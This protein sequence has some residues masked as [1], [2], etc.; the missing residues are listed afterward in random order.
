MWNILFVSP[1]IL[2]NKTAEHSHRQHCHVDGVQC[3]HSS[4]GRSWS[5]FWSWFWS[6]SCVLS[7]G[8]QNLRGAGASVASDWRENPQWTSVFGFVFTSHGSLKRLLQSDLKKLSRTVARMC[9]SGEDVEK[10]DLWAVGWSKRR[11]WK[12]KNSV[13]DWQNTP[14]PLTHHT[15]TCLSLA[16]SLVP[17]LDKT[18][19]TE[20]QNLV[21]NSVSLISSPPLQSVLAD[22]SPPA[23][24]I[25]ESLGLIIQWCRGKR[26]RRLMLAALVWIK[27]SVEVTNTQ[28]PARESQ[29]CRA[30]NTHQRS[31]INVVMWLRQLCEV[32]GTR[33]VCV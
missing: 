21:S 22:P 32:A 30:A 16:W 15:F 7:R 31:L 4:T 2:L 10:V 20:K 27:E 12:W 28:W 17:R 5:W 23:M 13:T 11:V 33:N 9:Q 14:K 29:G 8:Q 26:R 24:F 18:H 6:W 3:Y 19:K 25:L 1:H